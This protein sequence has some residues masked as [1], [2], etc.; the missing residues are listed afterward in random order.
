MTPSMRSLND[1]LNAV[2]YVLVELA[3]AVEVLLGG[4]PIPTPVGFEKR[5]NHVAE[6]VGVRL[7]Q[8]A[9]PQASVFVL[10][11]Q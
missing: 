6:R 3:E 8:P 10:L 9:A 7:Q 5:R 11:Y 1:A 2:L 4:I